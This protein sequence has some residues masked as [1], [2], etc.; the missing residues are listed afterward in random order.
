[1][2]NTNPPSSYHDAAVSHTFQGVNLLNMNAPK[3]AEMNNCQQYEN[4]QRT[5]FNTI[6]AVNGPAT[7]TAQVSPQVSL[8]AQTASLGM[9][10]D[11]T[12]SPFR[13]QDA[14]GAGQDSIVTQSANPCVLTTS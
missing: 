5:D 11:I 4:S 1:M 10:G 14:I 12:Y 2:N 13:L 7:A 6:N 8:Q 3:T 9:M